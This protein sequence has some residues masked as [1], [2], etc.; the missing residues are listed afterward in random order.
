LATQNHI[1]WSP[2]TC[3]CIV[4]LLIDDQTGDQTLFALRNICDAHKSIATPDPDFENKKTAAIAARY[5]V[6]DDNRN[7]NYAQIDAYSDLQ[8]PPKDKAALKANID[9]ITADRKQEYE[10]LA[11][12]SNLIFCQNV[13]DAVKE[14]GGRWG[15]ILQR[16]QQ[17]YGLTD[18]QIQAITFTYSGTGNNRILT[19]NTTGANLTNQ[20][21]TQA[22]TWADQNIGIGKVV[23][24]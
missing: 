20:Q 19:V 16:V 14:E 23:I 9:Q 24:L 4:D 17:Q 18:A 7:Q 11:A 12:S 5:K 21:K 22:Q 8:L 10:L 6:L 15:K 1:R 3:S 2:A 13:H